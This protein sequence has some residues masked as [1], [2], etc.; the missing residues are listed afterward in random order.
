MEKW[1]GWW[2]LILILT[3]GWTVWDASRP[4]W[5]RYQK[6]YYR[7]ALSRARNEAQRE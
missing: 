6:T 1:L 4:E 3:L 5:E 7:V 2:S